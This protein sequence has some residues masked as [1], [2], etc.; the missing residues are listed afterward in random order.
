MIQ[1]NLITSWTRRLDDFITRAPTVVIGRGTQIANEASYL[2]AHR[3]QRCCHV[4]IEQVVATTLSL[5]FEYIVR[6]LRD[7]LRHGVSHGSSA[8]SIEAMQPSEACAHGGCVIGIGK[9]V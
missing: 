8:T 2:L 1:E 7:C 9:T 6:W 5:R 4:I 3:A